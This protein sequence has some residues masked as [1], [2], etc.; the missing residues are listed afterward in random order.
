MNSRIRI[1]GLSFIICHLSFSPAGAQKL[2]VQQQTINCGKTGYEVPATATFELRNKGLK[3][4]VIKEVHPDCGCTQVQ[5][6]KKELGA[7]DKA[8]IK[9]T[10]DA[11]QLGHYVKQAAVYTNASDQPVYLT[12]KGV[13]LEELKD[14]SGVYP[15]AMG[16]LLADKNVLEFDDVNKGDH[17][18]QEIHILNNS[19]R[20]MT[21]NIQH[22]PSYLSA[23]VTPEKLAPGHAGKVSV[24]LNSENINDYGL[25][26]SSVY[27]ASNLGDKVSP[28]NEL[29][30]SVVLLPD[31]KN[32][33]GNLKQYAA[34]MELSDSVLTLGI[35][36]GKNHKSGT[37]LITNRGRQPLKISSMQMFTAGLKL[38]LGERE[39]QPGQ[40]TKLK[41]E[42]DRD[43]LL[44]ARS[45]PRVLMITNDPDHT[46][47]VITIQVK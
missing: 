33:E 24:M 11:R 7:N 3:R 12:M 23:I 45:K 16:E 1:L 30:I 43:K 44:K 13:V 21:P 29:P 25:T 28:D 10:Y 40:Q 35:I 26:Q 37:I 9:L 36:S 27:L 32:Y 8:T 14:Y 41:I 2:V 15:Y 18:I 34:R 39:L 46:K 42:A 19:E 4:L 5:V 22:L 6:S 20:Q 17:P 38:T 47:V 31:L